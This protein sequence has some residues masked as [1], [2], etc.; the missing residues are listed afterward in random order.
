MV[1]GRENDMTDLEMIL[2]KAKELGA[3]MKDSEIVAKYN[4]AKAAFDADAEI[5]D[6]VGQ[7]NLARM[8][9]T[10][11]SQKEQTDPELLKQLQEKTQSIYEQIMQKEAMRALD[12]AN[13]ALEDMVKQVNQILQNSISGGS[14]CTHDCSFCAGCH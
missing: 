6:L 10:E 5:N 9:L 14:A 2:E 12:G 11:Q 4:A 7:F 13:I 3:L 1:F 8:N